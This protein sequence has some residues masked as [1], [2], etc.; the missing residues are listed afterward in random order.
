VRNDDSALSPDRHLNRKLHSSVRS[1]V[2]IAFARGGKYHH[3]VSDFACGNC[4][5]S[6][7]AENRF[8]AGCGQPIAIPA[9]VVQPKKRPGFGSYLLLAFLLLAFLV[10]VGFQA[11][12]QSSKQ[13]SGEAQQPTVQAYY[14]V[15][16]E[17]LDSLKDAPSLRGFS[18]IEVLCRDMGKSCSIERSD[19]LQ[20]IPLT[21]GLRA[22]NPMKNGYM[23]SITTTASE[24]GVD[25]LLVIWDANAKER[26]WRKNG[27]IATD[28]D[29]ASYNLQVTMATAFSTAW[30]LANHPGYRKMPQLDSYLKL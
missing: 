6:I 18:D 22:S 24:Q 21:R 11:L 19:L 25:V 12:T 26:L 5:Q 16:G 14:R 28:R 2:R 7:S 8:C 1:K 3:G 9:V 30:L 23:L 29:K 10:V 15:F 13:A 4:G 20:S 17:T 27:I